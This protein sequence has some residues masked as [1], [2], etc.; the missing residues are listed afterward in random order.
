MF[1]PEDSGE[2]SLLKNLTR[3]IRPL[4]KSRNHFFFSSNLSESLQRNHRL[5]R[6]VRFERKSRRK[7]RNENEASGARRST[8][9]GTNEF[10][11]VRKFRLSLSVAGKLIFVCRSFSEAFEKTVKAI[12]EK[13]FTDFLPPTNQKFEEEIHLSIEMF[14][15]FAFFYFRRRKTNKAEEKRGNSSWKG[16]FILR[17]CPTD[18]NRRV[19]ICREAKNTF[20]KWRRT[21]KRIKTNLMQ[22]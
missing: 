1:H 16:F 10:T 9:T 19:C 2:F 20:F 17:R 15:S 4:T 22:K 11:S 18:N 13:L 14:E 21:T 6:S 8:T 12:P 3:K 7:R 5:R